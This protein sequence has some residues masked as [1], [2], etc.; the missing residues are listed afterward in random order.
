MAKPYSDDTG[1]GT[2]IH[3]SM[4][5]DAG[6]NVFSGATE[7]G[8][9]LLRHAVGGLFATMEESMAIYAPNANSYR[10][11]QEDSF[12]PLAKT[13]GWNNRTVAVRIPTGADEA[14]RLEHRVAGADANPFLLTAVLL[15]GMHHGI[16]RRIEPGEP[17]TGNA[18]QQPHQPLP[19]R[20][21]EALDAFDNRNILGGL[22]RPHA[23]ARR[24][25]PANMRKCVCS[26]PA[27]HH[28]N[29]SGT[30]DW[31]NALY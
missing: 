2:H 16:T 29:I 31:C 19:A 20:W 15:A 13:W 17:V 23:S 26:K 9:D 8:S 12:V 5:D 14:R 28:W 6:N 25:W 3:I 27:S 21:P 18:Y 7:I 4:L 10:R 1:S 24:T 30:C 22:S 11:F